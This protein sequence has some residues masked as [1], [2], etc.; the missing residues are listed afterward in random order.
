[1]FP[2]SMFPRRFYNSTLEE[3]RLSEC[4]FTRALR[5]DEGDVLDFVGLINLHFIKDFR[6]NGIRFIK[7]THLLSIDKEVRFLCR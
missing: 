1:M 3:H 7:S 6:V 2:L 5:S 4:G